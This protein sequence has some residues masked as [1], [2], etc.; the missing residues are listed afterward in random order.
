VPSRKGG[1]NYAYAG[2]RTGTV[3]G[4]TTPAAVPSMVA[5][6]EQYLAS[7]GYVTKPQYLFVVD[8]VT[9]G[10]NIMDALT[11]APTNPNAPAQVLTQAVTDVVGIIQRLYSAGARHVL[12]ANSTNIGRTPQAQAGGAA[13]VA[14]R[15]NCR[16][17][18]TARW[19]S[20]SRS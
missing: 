4:V 12:L 3:P 1:T 15:R 10:N 17:S 9:V 8:A 6:V 19:R 5:Q 20:R 16:S 14:G 18:S 7:V 2:A 13:A 11:L